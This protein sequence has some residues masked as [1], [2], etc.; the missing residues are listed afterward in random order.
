MDRGL[1]NS[2]QFN[3]P[4]LPSFY[5]PADQCSCGEAY[6]KRGRNRQRWVSLD[7]MSRVFQEFFGSIAALFCGTPHYSYAILYCIG[8][9]TGCARSPVRCFGDVFSR[10]FHYGL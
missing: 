5:H 4:D 9:R 2:I 7:A 6:R 8:N 3:F 1:I 10:S